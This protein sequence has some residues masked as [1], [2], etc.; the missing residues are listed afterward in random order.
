MGNMTLGGFR[1][2]NRGGNL[3]TG[4]GE[5]DFKSRVPDNSCDALWSAESNSSWKCSLPKSHGG[6]KNI[7]YERG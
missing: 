1:N 3:S 7:L 2:T 5:G 6:G 4:G